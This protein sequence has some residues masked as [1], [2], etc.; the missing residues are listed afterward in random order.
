MT[1]EPSDWESVQ[2]EATCVGDVYVPA[3]W[4]P[5]G[6]AQRLTYMSDV[7]MHE[8]KAAAFR[9]QVAALERWRRERKGR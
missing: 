1:P 7:C 2:R 4:S 6:W 8:H 5:R 3:G 9:R